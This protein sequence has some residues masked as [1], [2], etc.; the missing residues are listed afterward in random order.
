MIQ[1]GQPIKQRKEARRDFHGLGFEDLAKPLSDL[2]A[3]FA[4]MHVVEG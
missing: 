3:N 2:V 4:A 1:F